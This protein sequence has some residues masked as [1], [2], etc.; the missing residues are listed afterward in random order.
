MTFPINICSFC[1]SNSFSFLFSAL[2][3]L[4]LADKSFSLCVSIVELWLVL[5]LE[6]DFLIRYFYS[7][8]RAGFPSLDS[9]VNDLRMKVLSTAL[10]GVYWQLEGRL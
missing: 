9:G 2:I 1:L 10:R 7:L 5:I 6:I 8:N 3:A 4:Y